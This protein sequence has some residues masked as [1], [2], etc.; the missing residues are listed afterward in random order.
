MQVEYSKKARKALKIWLEEENISVYRFAKLMKLTYPAGNNLINKTAIPKLQTAI[1]IE[2]L[3]QGEVP[4]MLWKV[5]SAPKKKMKDKNTNH[6]NKSK[7]HDT[8]KH[9]KTSSKGK[10]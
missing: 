1:K 2:E 8:E 5:E 10:R 9:S 3:T 6:T 4:C 7:S